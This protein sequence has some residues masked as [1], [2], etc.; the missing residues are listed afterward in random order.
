MVAQGWVL[1]TGSCSSWDAQGYHSGVAS[2]TGAV[3]V[4]P[5]HHAS[6]SMGTLEPFEDRHH[7]LRLDS[8][9]LKGLSP[10]MV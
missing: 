8:G 3:L 6:L 9:C 10:C 4:L 1:G 7:S 2:P 5:E